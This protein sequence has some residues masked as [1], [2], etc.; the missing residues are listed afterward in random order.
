VFASS[1]YIP[2]FVVDVNEY[3]GAVALPFPALI[4]TVVDMTVVVSL[5]VKSSYF[6]ILFVPLFDMVAVPN[7]PVFFL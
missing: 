7:P 3:E 4:G 6:T 1:L 5:N 2:A